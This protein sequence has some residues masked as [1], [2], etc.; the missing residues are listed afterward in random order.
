MVIS[1]LSMQAVALQLCGQFQD[2]GARVSISMI[3]GMAGYQ[4]AVHQLGIDEVLKM[5]RQFG[6]DLEGGKVS[7]SAAEQE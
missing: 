7:C 1:G 5:L 4:I 6:I 2:N 3:P